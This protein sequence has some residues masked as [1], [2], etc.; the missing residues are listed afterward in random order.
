MR[1]L[2]LCPSA[3]RL[4][5]IQSAPTAALGRACESDPIR[6]AIHIKSGFPPVATPAARVT[7]TT[8]GPVPFTPLSLSNS[9]PPRS[10]VRGY[11]FP[12]IPTVTG[13]MASAP[14]DPP[15]HGIAG[16]GGCHPKTTHRCYRDLTLVSTTQTKQTVILGPDSSGRELFLR[17]RF[18]LLA[19]SLPLTPRTNC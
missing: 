11:S 4:N 10:R 14:P 13:S 5:P 18:C 8:N 12:H 2:S 1:H 7:A 15:E 3:N 16:C 6:P 9:A 19:L 17:F